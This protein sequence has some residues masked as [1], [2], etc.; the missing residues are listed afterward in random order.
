[1]SDHSTLTNLDWENS[2]HTGQLGRI[3]AFGVGGVALLA[4][5]TGTDNKIAVGTAGGEDRAT[6]WDADGNLRSAP[7][8]IKPNGDI[9]DATKVQA[10][11]Y[12]SK[13]VITL[14][15][16]SGLDVDLALSNFF[17]YTLTSNDTLNFPT[18]LRVCNFQI[19]VKQDASGGHVL[20]LDTQ[21]K[22]ENGNN[23]ALAT[24]ANAENIITGFCD[25]CKVYLVKN[26][27]FQ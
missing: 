11:S 8:K 19:L 17:T 22:T 26:I 5:R 21:Y 15:D 18:N 27:N 10:E 9:E 3:A 6:V 12:S 4:E 13:S 23:L 20:T 7:V 16:T 2:G 1:M 24:S 14:D 25:G